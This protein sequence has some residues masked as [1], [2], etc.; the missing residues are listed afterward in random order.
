MI[1]WCVFEGYAYRKVVCICVCVCLFDCCGFYLI[2]MNINISDFV[3]EIKNKKYWLIIKF[4]KVH[5]NGI[6]E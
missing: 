3:N 2:Y 6:Y 5:E 1:D 4:L